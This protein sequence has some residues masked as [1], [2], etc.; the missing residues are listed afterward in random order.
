MTILST[1][2]NF[3]NEYDQEEEAL[4]ATLFTIAVLSEID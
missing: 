4:Y 1:I 2:S 3:F